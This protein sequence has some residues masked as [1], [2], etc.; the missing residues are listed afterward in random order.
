MSG[1]TVSFDVLPMARVQ[2]LNPD[3][4]GTCSIAKANNRQQDDLCH[5]GF[6]SRT[7]SGDLKRGRAQSTSGLKEAEASYNT[8]KI[9][10]DT[11]PVDKKFHNHDFK[12]VLEKHLETGKPTDEQDVPPV[13]KPSETDANVTMDSL[14]AVIIVS[15]GQESAQS[16]Q[17][18]A[19][20]LPVLQQSLSATVQTST[21]AESNPQPASVSPLTPQIITIPQPQSD[22]QMTPNQES[23]NAT[24]N[25][26]APVSPD[27]VPGGQNQTVEANPPVASCHSCSPLHI[28]NTD[29]EGADIVS[30]QNTVVSNQPDLSENLSNTS[31]DTKSVDVTD[32]PV[33]TQPKEQL[34]ELPAQMIVSAASHDSTLESKPAG[35]NHE[36][37]RPK[38][39]SS[40]IKSSASRDAQANRLNTELPADGAAQKLGIEKINSSAGGL[41]DGKDGSPGSNQADSSPLLSHQQVVSSQPAEVIPA[42][43]DR[44]GVVA[45][46]GRSAPSDDRGSAGADNA[47]SSIRDQI[48]QSVQVAARQADRQITIQ[49]NPPELGRVSIKFSERGAELTGLLETTNPQT[50]AEIHNAVPEIIRSLEQSGVA[51]KRIDVALSDLS[52]QPAQDS[53]RDNYPHYSWDRSGN[54]AFNDS[55]HPRPSYDSFLQSP[56]LSQTSDVGSQT[57]FALN[58]TQSF[59]SSDVFLDVLI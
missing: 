51:V 37:S 29:G 59:S 22:G 31:M 38:N 5:T 30:S 25:T 19:A 13:T 43:P 52:R 56:Y 26:I 20:C 16:P 23:A 41:L 21:T 42:N 33:S 55:D 3:K 12:D 36:N 15:A 1:N 57:F 40:L 24:G 4:N 49:L 10:T 28:V 2:H 39:I 11:Q 34:T 50:R 14:Q 44:A 7:T 45:D 47:S 46:L 35:W 48:F 8:A 9:E 54:Y 32:Q 18:A 17:D 27:L 6:V 58:Q 53:Q